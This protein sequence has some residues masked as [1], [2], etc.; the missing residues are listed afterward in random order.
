MKNIIHTLI[1][2]SLVMSCQTTPQVQYT[3]ATAPVEARVE[4][5]MSQ[6]TL[7]EKIGQMCQYVAPLHIEESKK[8]IKG[9][10]LIHNDQW[11]LYPGMSSDSLRALV[12]SGEIGSFLHVKDAKEANDLQRLA[13]ET[14]LKIP[15]LIGIDA[16]H[17]HAMIEGSTVFPT[18][19]G[20]SSSWD[21][22]LLYQVAKATA[23]E[24]RATGMHWTF[25]PNVDVA[26]DPRWGRCGETFGEDPYMVTQ[27]GL[28]FTNGY[29][30][31]FGE[32]NVLACA[33]HFIAG[34]EPYNGTN[35]SPMDAS[36]RQLRE[37]WLPPYKAQVDANVFTFM[38]AH[39][40]LNGIPCHSNKMLLTDIL[41]DE[42][43]YD[44]F[45]VSDWMDIERIEKLHHV[46]AN[47]KDAIRLSVDA[48]MDMHMH[49]PNFLTPLAEL[50]RSGAID[51]NKINESCRKILKA[52]FMLGLFED[53]F[54][55]E[56]SAAKELFSEEH[57]ALSIEAAR[58]SIV[59]LKNDGLL[60]FTSQ[61]KILVTGPN[62]HNHRLM[63][64]WALPQPE[65][66]LTTIYEGFQQ[67]FTDAQVDYVN[68]GE[69][70]RNP[71]AAA[72]EAAVAKAKGYDAIVVAVGSNS[73]RYEKDEKNC[74]ENV[75]RSTINL[76]GNQL[77]LVKR[78]Y[79]IN[80]N[81]VI[82]LVNGRPLSEP[83]IKENIPAIIEA[84]EPGS[85]GGQ[86][87][88]EIVKGDVN[89]S[90]KLTMTFPYHVG[91]VPM[92]Y[93]KKPSV[94]FHK[95]IDAPSKPLWHFGYGLSY[96]QFAY[97]Q[98]QLSASSIAPDTSV[99]VS[100]TITNTGSLPGD[101][102]AQLYI[103]DEVS[104]VTRPVKEL[105]GYQRVSLAPKESK[106]IV[107]ELQ[108]KDLAF[109]D[110]DMKYGVEKGTFQIMVG[111]SS[112]DK[113]LLSAKLELTQSKSIDQ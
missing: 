107:F 75:G 11:G 25:S 55:D 102:I 62:A 34:S 89:P 63:G 39:N 112:A 36:M 83:W 90:G 45:V 72:L 86:A 44:G 15:L 96:T 57:Q 29:Q 106:Q 12:S 51:E 2:G 103:R 105:K 9:E 47:A 21:N 3:D 85:F 13:K 5:L 40:E 84:W 58:K 32:D 92:V 33:K 53:P 88:A 23:K 27:M 71:D 19:L 70:L 56:G 80:K 82:V 24:V 104:S 76:M 66:K 95:Y 60:P 43:G 79:K 113:D 99:Q 93:N 65:D 48:G 81:I 26:R 31:D 35:A 108:A 67:V 98:L 6:M 1:V 110:I 101:E 64:D 73:L 87:I 28:A 18:Q 4:S 30:G 59:L 20:L 54:V 14:R 46:A 69:S 10:E 8:R 52:K 16:I 91:Q 42:W 78:L 94:F 100:V 41:R 77:E 111:T 37:I 74:G 22:E 7:E 97:D 50:V 61:K 38:A 49:G 109:Y 17:G 68:S